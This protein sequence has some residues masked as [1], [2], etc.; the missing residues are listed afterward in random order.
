MKSFNSLTA[1]TAQ[2]SSDSSVEAPRCGVAI[3]FF[4]LAILAL[5]K[6][7]TYLFTFLSANAA[8]TAASSTKRSLA[9]FKITTPSFIISIAFLSIMP[10]VESNNGTCTVI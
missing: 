1:I 5:G 7:V 3:T 9:K 8:T 2:L 4:A 6:S 10:F